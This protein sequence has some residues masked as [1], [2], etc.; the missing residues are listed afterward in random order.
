MQKIV[1]LQIEHIQLRE[2]LCSLH[3][4]D[5]A[6]LL[7]FALLCFAAP[8]LS[9]LTWRRVFSPLPLE[10]ASSYLVSVSLSRVMCTNKN[11]ARTQACSWWLHCFVMS[12]FLYESHLCLL[13]QVEGKEKEQRVDVKV[14]AAKWFL[15]LCPLSFIRFRKHT[16]LLPRSWGHSGS[17]LSLWCSDTD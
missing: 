6:A 10:F 17:S 3:T 4:L 9:R 15:C 13:R 16:A 12:V 2:A 11:P 14:W 1:I 8:P 7:C 5:G